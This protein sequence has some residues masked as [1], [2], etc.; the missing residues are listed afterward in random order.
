MD[1][2][3]FYKDTESESIDKERYR[4]LIEYIINKEGY[5]K[6]KISVI[7]TSDIALQKINKEFLGK[8][9]F[10]DIVVFG[11]SFKNTVSGEVYISIDRIRENSIKY[12]GGEFTSEL[13]RVII[14]GILHLLGYDDK[15][16]DEREN[17]LNREELYL[18]I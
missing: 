13:K 17:M 12:S 16:E 10:T 1:V 2:D 14:H 5:K 9:Y 8:E 11:N 18:K 6:G 7:I 15:K 3:F 4:R